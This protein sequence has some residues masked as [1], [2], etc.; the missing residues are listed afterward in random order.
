M[1]TRRLQHY[2]GR[3]PKIDTW[4]GRD[5]RRSEAALKKVAGIEI[6]FNIDLRPTD[7]GDKDGLEIRRRWA[8]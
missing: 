1:D 3:W 5:I 8:P 2:L 4:L 7:E 6:E